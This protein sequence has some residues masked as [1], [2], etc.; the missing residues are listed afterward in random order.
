MAKEKTKTEKGPAKKEVKVIVKEIKEKKKAKK[1]AVPK[2]PKK[3]EDK[4]VGL[5]VAKSPVKNKVKKNIFLKIGRDNFMS[6]SPHLVD[7]RKK[8]EDFKK[9]ESS[10][11]GAMF[12][13]KV[14]SGLEEVG[15]SCNRLVK[16]FKRRVSNFNYQPDFLRHQA[17]IR[18]ELRKPKEPMVNRCDRQLVNSVQSFGFFI[19][20]VYKSFPRA[21]RRILYLIIRFLE[22]IGRSMEAIWSSFVK[23]PE[24]PKKPAFNFKKTFAIYKPQP[25][26]VWYRAVIGFFIIC[27]IL[28]LPIRGLA[29]YF[30]LHQ[31]GNEVLGITKIALERLKSGGE[32]SMQLDLVG[33]SQEFTR[34]WQGFNFAQEQLA[35]INN[36]ILGVIKLVPKEGEM[37]ASAERLLAIGKD[38]SSAGNYLANG[39]EPLL[40]GGQMDLSSDIKL[41]DETASYNELSLTDKVVNLK[42]N[43]I[44][45]QERI[46]AVQKNLDQVDISSLPSEYQSSILEAKESLSGIEKKIGAFYNFT[47]FLTEILGH[48][49]TQR[50]LL[51]FENNAE[52]RATGGFIGSLALMDIDRGRI[53]NIEIPGGGPYDL[54]AGFH[55][56][57]ISPEPLQLVNPRW[58]LQDSNWFPD[59][60][61]SAQKVIWFYN[62][63]GGPT[64][65]GVIA[66][67]PTLIEKLIA[68][69]GPIDMSEDYGIVITDKNFIRFAQTEA[70]KKYDETK[71]SKQFIAD[72]TPKVLA[73]ALQGDG[74]H[75]LEVLKVLSQALSDKNLLFYLTDENLE[76]KVLGYGWGGEFKEA[77]GDYLAII[78]S[79]I[80][81]GKTDMVMEEK[82]SHQA[83]IDRDGNIIDTLTIIRQH[84]GVA[85]DPFTGFKNVDYLRVYVPQGSQLISASGFEEPWSGL[86]PEVPSDYQKDKDLTNISGEVKIDPLSKTRINNEFGKTVFGNWVQTE[87]GETSVVTIKYRLPFQLPLIK[88]RQEKNWWDNFKSSLGIKQDSVSYSLFV[89]KQPGSAYNAFGQEV[90]FKFS[91][92]VIWQYPSGWQA[93]K[94]DWQLEES[95]DG[96]KFYGLVFKE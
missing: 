83:E 2:K 84:N 77:P 12:L 34:A 72:L 6:R 5:D 88:I 21:I 63:S 51:I 33:A 31:A 52:L 94:D 91:P 89:Q 14:N 22:A 45:A 93:N 81:G 43:F 92:Q 75:Y 18:K 1:K 69:V 23:G 9:A 10:S 65:D 42:N 49:Q 13:D 47:D 87:V 30:K 46:E 36:V 40:K 59:F 48:Y 74:G 66:L 85:N 71:T 25:I 3:Q 4:S 90:N 61:T 28:V 35:E 15:S 73:K 38:I 56:N 53:K 39:L 54:R 24:S 44:L 37:V 64:V 60:P 57:I 68:L 62:K 8:E 27:L 50:Y 29:Y 55:E 11:E 79:N 67:T 80:S 41:P 16:G 7:L 20:K 26:V 78:H 86:F 17:K 95:L 76:K 70:E 96:D 58:E 82:V 32:A 19:W